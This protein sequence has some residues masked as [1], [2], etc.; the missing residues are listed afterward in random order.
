MNSTG[1]AHHVHNLCL[2]V[3]HACACLHYYK[4]YRELAKRRVKHGEHMASR[5]I[6]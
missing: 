1:A 5:P 6:R 3:D 2:P 4:C